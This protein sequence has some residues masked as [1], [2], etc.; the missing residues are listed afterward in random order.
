MHKWTADVTVVKSIGLFGK[1]LPHVRGHRI[2]LLS[3]S[4]KCLTMRTSSTGNFTIISTCLHIT[5]LVSQYLPQ[6]AVLE[7]TLPITGRHVLTCTF[8]HCLAATSKIQASLKVTLFFPYLG[9]INQII[10]A[11]QVISISLTLIQWYVYSGYVESK[12]SNQMCCDESN[13]H[14]LGITVDLSP[15]FEC[16]VLKS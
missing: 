15:S 6:V 7:D 3:G 5:T 2:N 1:G 14:E 4:S 12:L 11:S 10:V 8:F 16:F 13:I 9:D